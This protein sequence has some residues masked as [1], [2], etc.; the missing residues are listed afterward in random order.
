VVIRGIN[1]QGFIVLGLTRKEIEG[2][3][4]GKVCC[5]P[6][7]KPT[8][9][10]PHICVHFGETNADAAA[11]VER[12]FASGAPKAVDLRTKPSNEDN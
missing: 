5:F 4:A 7:G 12:S 6:A 3:L 8:P 1:A 11:A 9:N 10:S 2:L